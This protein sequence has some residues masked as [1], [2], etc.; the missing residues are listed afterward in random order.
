MIKQGVCL[1]WEAVV[2]EID[3]KSHEIFSCKRSFPNFCSNIFRLK[4]WN[5]QLRN[6]FSF[7]FEIFE[8]KTWNFYL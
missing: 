7:I 1:F 6:I 4:S 3:T 2:I 8:V 5:F